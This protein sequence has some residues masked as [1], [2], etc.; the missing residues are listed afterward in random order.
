MRGTPK[1]PRSTQR[2]RAR[3]VL[4]KSSRDY[5]CEDCGCS[6]VGLPID[7]PKHLKLAPKEKRTVSSLQADHKSKNIMDN[8]PANLAWKCPRCHKLSDSKTKKGVIS[9]NFGYGLGDLDL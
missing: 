7:A 5:I 6:P 9:E 4:F 2:K 1:D 3:K 8:D